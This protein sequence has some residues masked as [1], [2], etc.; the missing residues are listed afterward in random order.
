MLPFE[1][2]TGCFAENVLSLDVIVV[3]NVSDSRVVQFSLS[4]AASK[5]SAN[6][7]LSVTE[8][9]VSVLF[10][11]NQT[12][13]QRLVA[14]NRLGSSPS[15][16]PKGHRRRQTISVY[17]LNTPPRSSDEEGA[18]RSDPVVGLLAKPVAMLTVTPQKTRWLKVL[19]PTSVAQAAI[20]SEDQ[21]LR[22]LI[23]C[24][25]CRD[26]DEVV[27]VDE[28]TL[29]LP[30]PL[31]SPNTRSLFMPKKRKP[32]GDDRNPDRRRLPA[33]ERAEGERY[34][35]FLVVHTKAKPKPVSMTMSDT[36]TTRRSSCRKILGC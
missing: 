24:G 2:S 26:G 1:R 31:Q 28:P 34:F 30:A 29:K 6:T 3:S 14:P 36:K 4:E 18:T 15:S 12:T 21:V 23:T 9:T 22:L 10:R 35:P 7:S 13:N 32:K 17:V 20:D 27:L 25:T 11:L 19:L 8:A 33:E 5:R 16:L